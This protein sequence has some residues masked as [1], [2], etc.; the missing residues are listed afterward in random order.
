MKASEDVTRETPLAEPDTQAPTAPTGLTA[1]VVSS[2]QINLGWGAS[3][4]NVGVSRYRV[5]RCVVASCTSGFIELTPLPTGPSFNN[6]GLAPATSYR[7]R[8]RAEDAAG[9][10]SG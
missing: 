2:T 4:D 3:T 6:V 1:T 8:V 7:Y 5:E 9:H 10:L